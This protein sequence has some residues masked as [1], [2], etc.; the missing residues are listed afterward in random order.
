GT[1]AVRRPLGRSDGAPLEATRRQPTLSP[2]D[3]LA[4]RADLSR[5]SL[6]PDVVAY[7]VE[8]GRA[9]RQSPDLQLGSSVRGPLALALGSRALAALR[10]RPYVTPDDVKE[11]VRPALRHRVVLRPDAEIEGLSPDDVLGR[12]LAGVEVP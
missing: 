2:G 9:T 8:I 10:G 7:I 4:C 11:L 12:A 6:E 3:L 1:G 5:V